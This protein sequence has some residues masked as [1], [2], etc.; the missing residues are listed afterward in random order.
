VTADELP[1]PPTVDRVVRQQFNT[2]LPPELIDQ[3]RVFA[4]ANRSTVQAVTEAALREYMGRRGAP[5]PPPRRDHSRVLAAL[6]DLDDPDAV[7]ALLDRLRT[8]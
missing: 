3:A 1:M 5:V 7:Q 2:K 8:E 4:A 6:V